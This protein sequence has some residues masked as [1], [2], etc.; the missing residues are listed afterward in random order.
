MV[1]D[2]LF[3]S[4]VTCM[5]EHKIVVVGHDAVG[6]SACVVQ[7]ILS[8]FIEEYEYTIEDSYRRQVTIDDETCLLDILDTAGLEVY[9]AMRPQYMRSGQ[10]FLLVYSITSRKSFDMVS[11]FREQILREKNSDT[12]PIVLVGNKQDEFTQRQ[13][14]TEEG[15]E[16]AQ[17][18]GCPFLESSAKTRL[19]VHESF[20]EL[21]R[22][23]RRMN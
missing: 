11:S 4:N 19:N 16:L 14:S 7:L 13:V 15:R 20:Y 17:L 21:V 23:I 18:F 22:E 6:K 2:L 3:F 12:V 10:G 5:T 9:S 8:H 1:F